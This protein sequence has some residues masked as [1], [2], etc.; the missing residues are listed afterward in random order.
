MNILIFENEYTF[1]ENAFNYVNHRYFNGDLKFTVCPKSQDLKPFK[2][3]ENYDHVFIDISLALKS[4]LDGFGILKK[5]KDENL[6]VKKITI[7]TGN[8]NISKKLEEEEL[9]NYPIIVKPITF[10]DLKQRLG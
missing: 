5:I 9:N 2:S 10:H 8:N 6:K 3:I 1:I 4:D 7:I